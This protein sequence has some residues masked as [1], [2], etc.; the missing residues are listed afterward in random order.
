MH[1]EG[2][3]ERRAARA[4][5]AG[6][7]PQ[8]PPSAPSVPAVASAAGAQSWGLS[9]ETESMLA[10]RPPLVYRKR[11][12]SAARLPPPPTHPDAREAGSRH[13]PRLAP[14]LAPLHLAPPRLTST[15]PHLALPVRRLPLHLQA[16]SA[17]TRRHLPAGGRHAGWTSGLSR[18]RAPSWRLRG[19]RCC[20]IRPCGAPRRA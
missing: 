7:A 16:R 17:A 8:P 9:T 20:R 15:S 14:H 6:G 18:L 1:E 4:R 11:A 19:K 2:E 5:E 13:R 10:S 12:A 3:R